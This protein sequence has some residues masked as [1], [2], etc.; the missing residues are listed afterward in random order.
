MWYCGCTRRW[1]RPTVRWMSSTFRLTHSTATYSSSRGRTTA[2][3]WTSSTTIRW[4]RPSTMPRQTRY[5]RHTADTSFTHHVVFSFFHDQC[6]RIRRPILCFQMS[7]MCFLTFL[8][9]HVKSRLQKFSCQSFK[10]SSQLRWVIRAIKVEFGNSAPSS[11]SVIRAW[12][13]EYD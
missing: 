1:S 13:G 6:L 2:T 4:I 10:T 9:R 12:L 7:K 5:I 8:N 11:P 3:S